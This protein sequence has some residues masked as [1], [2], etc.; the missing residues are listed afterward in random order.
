[1][2]VLIRAITYA[3]LFIGFVLVYVPGTLLSQAGLTR[4]NVLR[5]PQFVGI[6]LGGAGAIVAVWCIFT[7]IVVGKGTPAPFDPPRRLVVV[8]PYRYVR[9]PMYIGAAMA[10][11]GAALFYGSW[12]LLGYAIFLGVVTHLFIVWYE[13]PTLRGA[14]GADYDAYCQRVSRWWP[15]IKAR[16]A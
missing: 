3:T 6:V 5:A 2:F 1:M 15:R 14:F 11:S 8:G 4:P 16:Q 10:M 13:E 7:F 9:N 12:W